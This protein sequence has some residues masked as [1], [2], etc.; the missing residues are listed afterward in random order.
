MGLIFRTSRC[1]ETMQSFIEKV[2]QLS[3]SYII[4]NKGELIDVIGIT[5]LQQALKT[6]V[7]N[8]FFG[9]PVELQ[10]KNKGDLKTMTSEQQK[11][12]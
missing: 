8:M 12:I 7:D 3:P 9:S 10:N 4:N 11:W 5:E 6:E 1:T 2:S